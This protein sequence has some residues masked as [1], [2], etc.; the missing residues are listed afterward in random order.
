MR[1]SLFL[2]FLFF[3]TLTFAQSYTVD[4][5]PNVQLSD[6][7]K[8]VSNP[9]NILSQRTVASL[10]TMLYNLRQ[11]TTAEFVVVALNSIGNQNPRQFATKLFEKWGIGNKENDNG[12]LLLFIKDQ[13]QALTEV[14]YGLEGILPDAI[15][16]R[17]MMKYMFP[18]FKAGDY[19]QGMMEGV[20]A[21]AGVI[22]SDDNR[23]EVH[24]SRSEEGRAG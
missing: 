14:G 8:F 11:T 4:K 17:I 12:L 6:S 9:D 15:N 20:R 3:A 5:V 2:I 13:R 18:S 10:D 19:D 24:A 1:K 23:G 7:R 22:S 16:K 21:F